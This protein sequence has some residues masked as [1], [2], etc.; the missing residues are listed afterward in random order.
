MSLFELSH[1][2][3]T[4]AGRAI[5]D[6]VS[7]SLAECRIQA[8]F[9]PSGSGKTSLLRV[10][11][12]MT[13][14]SAG[15]IRYRGVETTSM[16]PLELR[17][18]VAIVFQEPVVLD[19]SVRDNLLVPFRFRR[20]SS[21]P[22]GDDELLRVILQSQLDGDSLSREASVL[23]GGEKQRLAVARS[24]L[25]NPE[26]MLLDEPTS[27]LDV[28]LARS[29]IESLMGNFPAIRFIIVTHSLELLAMADRQFRLVQGRIQGVFETHD[30]AELEKLVGERAN[31]ELPSETKE[32]PQ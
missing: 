15:S 8:I 2:R 9:G 23:S 31:P 29:L 3:L 22:P 16:N 4:R 17:R 1:L 12:L 26:V 30:R 11:N 20:D 14:P 32:I 28:S 18:K 13:I 24:L 6:D 7:L 21:I 25:T 5:L 27:A 10:L 19:G